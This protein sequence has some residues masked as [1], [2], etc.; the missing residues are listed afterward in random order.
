MLRQARK[1]VTRILLS[2]GVNKLY[3]LTPEEFEILER[4]KN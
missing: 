2:S 1:G 3:G 4:Q